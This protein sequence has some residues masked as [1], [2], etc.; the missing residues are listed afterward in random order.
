MVKWFI[1]TQ[2]F[3]STLP[4]CKNVAGITFKV[5]DAKC[6]FQSSGGGSACWWHKKFYKALNSI[7][8][9]HFP[10]ILQ[11]TN[12]QL[13]MKVLI[14]SSTSL[15][16]IN[17]SILASQRRWK[18]HYLLFSFHIFTTEVVS[19]AYFLVNYKYWLVKCHY[20]GCQLSFNFLYIIYMIV[21]YYMWYYISYIS[22]MWYY[23][24]FIYIFM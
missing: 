14:S 22:H 15:G 7:L 20:V 8:P 23:I 9:K 11:S 16:I 1:K 19:F 18:W 10:E 5:D 21:W 2:K 17:F 4:D 12:Q 3:Y 6:L 13:S 24:Y